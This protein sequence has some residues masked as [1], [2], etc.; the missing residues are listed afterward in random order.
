MISRLKD[1]LPTIVIILDAIDQLNDVRSYSM[2]RDITENVHFP[3]MLK[4]LPVS[5]HT[6]KIKVIVSCL[7]NTKPFNVIR[8]IRTQAI[9]RIPELNRENKKAIVNK[10]HETYLKEVDES[11]LQ[12]LFDSKE[13]GNIMFCHF[14]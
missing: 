6:N 7:E 11:K 4:W 9:L 14:L 10:W 13:C 8:T 5:F 2:G 12:S 1:K 3:S